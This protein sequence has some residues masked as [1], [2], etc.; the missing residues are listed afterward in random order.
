MR[1]TCWSA[2]LTCSSTGSTR[3]EG[4]SSKQKEMPPF[5]RCE[6]EH[7]RK[8]LQ[9]APT[10]EHCALFQPDIPGDADMGKLCNLFTAQSRSPR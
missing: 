6:F 10:G 2:G 4:L 1:E 8:T 5:I 9:P 3:G 7:T